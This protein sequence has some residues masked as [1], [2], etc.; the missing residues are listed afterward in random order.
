MAGTGERRSLAAS[1]LQG[2]LTQLQGN[3]VIPSTLT[4]KER[5]ELRRKDA[6]EYGRYASWQ[7]ATTSLV[8]CL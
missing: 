8:A 5:T 2:T 7:A 1:Q 3:I 4:Y 6:Y